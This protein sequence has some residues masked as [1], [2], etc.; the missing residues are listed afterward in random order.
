MEKWGNGVKW[1]N[2]ERDMRV[3]GWEFEDVLN[4]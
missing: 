1:E 4:Y 3:K 2:G